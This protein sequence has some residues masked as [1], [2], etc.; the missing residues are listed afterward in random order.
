SEYA[1]DIISY[2]AGFIARSLTKVIKCDTC[3]MALVGKTSESKLQNR[4]TESGLISASQ[5]LIEVC[6]TSG[7]VVR[8]YPNYQYSSWNFS[9][10]ADK[11]E[12]A[13]K[14]MNMQLI[15]RKVLLCL[16]RTRT[17]IRLRE[18]NKQISLQNQR[19]KQ[20]KKFLNLQI[21]KLISNIN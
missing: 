16:V 21:A 5:D 4:K 19:S 14:K 1:R 11:T 7:Y 8:T 17:Y 6:I 15:P 10:S 3:F 12:Q 9:K 2:I 20:I 18:I 13:M